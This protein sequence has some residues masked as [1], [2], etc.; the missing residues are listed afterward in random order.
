M[1]EVAVAVEVGKQSEV[2]EVGRQQR[3]V[4]PI[5]RAHRTGVGVLMH[6]RSTA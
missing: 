4:V 6:T 3:V 2:V 5:V 1:E